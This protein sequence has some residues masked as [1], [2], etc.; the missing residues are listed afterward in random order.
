MS[1]VVTRLDMLFEAE[2]MTSDT[3]AALCQLTKLQ[4]LGLSATDHPGDNP[5]ES[6]G[7]INLDLPWLIQLEISFMTLKL[8]S[9]NCPKLTA[10]NLQHVDV[11]GLTGVPGSIHKVLLQNVQGLPPLQELMPAHSTTML[12]EL[13][14]LDCD[15]FDSTD[16]GAVK[17]LCMNGKMRCL[18]LDDPS[19]HAGA[20]SE[21]AL[22]QAI[23]QTLE[24]MALTLPLDEGIPR[25]LEQLSGLTTLSLTHSKSNRMHLD[26]PLDPFLEMPRLKKLELT[27]T[28]YSSMMA[29]AGAGMCIWTPP[30]LRL[31]GLAEKRIRQMQNTP[32]GR[33]ID[34]SY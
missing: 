10:L 17:E 30:A 31:L 13:T 34:L 6:R 2:K 1:A 7:T 4:H 22:W 18:R 27:S 3:S 32:P 14:I 15:G 5:E 28:W 8:I 11:E 20:F 24:D 12:E 26:R 25:S 29:D 23:P 16:F 33:S 19:F 21:G 9:L